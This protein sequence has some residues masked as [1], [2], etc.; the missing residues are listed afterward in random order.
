MAE[1]KS[2]N[3]TT[4]A[5]VPF[6]GPWTTDNPNVVTRVLHLF[7]GRPP[8]TNA[9][10]RQAVAYVINDLGKHGAPD[11]KIARAC[12]VSVSL[13]AIVRKELEAERKTEADFKALS[14]AWR[15]ASHAARWRFSEIVGNW[16]GE[17]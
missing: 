11:G 8:E 1:T 14:D 6:D 13:V 9:E 12:F 5:T 16:N 2:Q 4:D 15:T 3:L 17:A 10:K 7:S